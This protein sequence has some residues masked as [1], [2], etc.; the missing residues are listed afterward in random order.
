MS[1]ASQQSL[2][3]QDCWMLCIGKKV[4]S[5]AVGEYCCWGIT[6]TTTE[7]H[8]RQILAYASNTFV[9]SP[10]QSKVSARFDCKVNHPLNRAQ[11]PAL[12]QHIVSTQLVLH[13]TKHPCTQCSQCCDH[14]CPPPLF[15]LEPSAGSLE[16]GMT[17]ALFESNSSNITKEAALH[18]YREAS[19]D[20]RALA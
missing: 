9:P 4:L 19:S 8:M 2:H 14:A 5:C 10:L 17:S 7:Q 11:C 6:T 13:K 3:F 12:D 15:H 20:G 18:V 1:T 16:L